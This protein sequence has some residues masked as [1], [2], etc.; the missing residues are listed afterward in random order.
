[1]LQGNPKTNKSTH[2][3]EPVHPGEIHKE[4]FLEPM[5]MTPYRLAQLLHVT[6]MRINQIV[7]RKRAISADTALRLARLF[8]NS[9]AFWLGLQNQ[10]DLDQ[11]QD[12]HGKA[13]ESEITALKHAS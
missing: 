5:G 11:A 7:N 3:L 13:I 1:M 10:Y 9:A 12:R 2:L 4:E 6:P 8:G